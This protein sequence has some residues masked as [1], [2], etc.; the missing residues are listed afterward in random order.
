MVPFGN[1][2]RTG[3]LMGTVVSLDGCILEFDRFRNHSV[4]R[5][6]LVSKDAGQTATAVDLGCIKPRVV[7]GKI[8]GG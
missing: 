5:V 7:D 1:Q 6:A 2:T 4:D 3:A 8:S